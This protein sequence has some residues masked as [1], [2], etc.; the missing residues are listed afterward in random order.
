MNNSDHERCSEL[1]A[2]HVRGELDANERDWVETHLAECADCRAE[3][4]A[5][6]ALSRE[7]VEPLTEIERA[8][9]RRAVLGSVQSTPLESG[10][11]PGTAGPFRTET[12]PAAVATGGRA[13]Q[14]LG[15]A[16]LVL[17]AAVF[18][19]STGLLGGGDAGLDDSAGGDAGLS[20]EA[21]APAT[22]EDAETFDE[23]GGGGSAASMAAA[24]EPTFRRSLGSITGKRLQK[25]GREGLP[26]VIFSRAYSA[27]QVPDLQTRFRDRLADAAGAKS[28][29]VRQCSDLVTSAFPNSLP[30]YGALATLEKLK[31]REVLVLAF[32]WTDRSSGPLDQSMV[33]AWPSDNCDQPVEYYKNVIQPEQ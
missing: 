22:V 12:G 4:A 11:A 32:A 23:A 15:A 16:A 2:Q 30:A 24:P 10:S 14:L 1:L 29:V 18:M 27:E 21:E 17:I 26:L 8:R 33:W 25:L 5:L 9:L 28:D 31:G 19:F 7:E 13:F 20:R 6:Q 3:Q